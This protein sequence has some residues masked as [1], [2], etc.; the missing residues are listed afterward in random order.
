MHIDT[1]NEE[2]M[3]SETMLAIEFGAGTNTAETITAQLSYH[4]SVAAGLLNCREQYTELQTAHERES[5]THSDRLYD[6]AAMIFRMA[7]ALSDP[8]V[9]RAFVAF[10]DWHDR[11][12]PRE[13][14][15]RCSDRTF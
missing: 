11:R 10:P 1:R 7:S 6:L 8:A 4:G 13:K 5:Y 14:G 3:P 12:R 2:P 9:W 15:K